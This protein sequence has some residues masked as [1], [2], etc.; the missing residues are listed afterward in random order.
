MLNDT[1]ALGSFTCLIYEAKNIL[2]HFRICA[3]LIHEI[4]S[5]VDFILSSAVH[6]E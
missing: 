2:T 4:F 6:T 3:Y 5:V 1:Y